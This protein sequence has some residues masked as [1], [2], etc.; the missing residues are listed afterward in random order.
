MPEVLCVQ[1]F[2]GRNKRIRAV[3]CG[4]T[5]LPWPNSQGIRLRA[6]KQHWRFWLRLGCLKDDLHLKVVKENQA[7]SAEV[8]DIFENF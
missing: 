6:F 7:E 1:V 5:K 4:N 2:V 3:A 8:F